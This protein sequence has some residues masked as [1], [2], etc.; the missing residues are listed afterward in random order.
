MRIPDN[1]ITQINDLIDGHRAACEQFA[2]NTHTS[3]KV[4]VIQRDEIIAEYAAE[5]AVLTEQ[6]SSLQVQLSTVQATA[7]D[8]ESRIA[9]YENRIA[10]LNAAIDQAQGQS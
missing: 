1:N 7:T 6:V 3:L 4:A 2:M 9:D 8:L 5:N 10:V